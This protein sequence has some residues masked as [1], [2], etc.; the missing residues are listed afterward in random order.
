M[1]LNILELG[2]MT[3]KKD[4][5]FNCTQMVISMKESG[6]VIRD[7]VK[8]Y[9]IIIMEISLMELLRMIYVQALE[10]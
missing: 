4:L 7:M 6:R 10:F 1:E 8:V 9:A 3:T 2:R 5:V